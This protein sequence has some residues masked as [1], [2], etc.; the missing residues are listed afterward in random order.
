MKKIM[1]ILLVLLMLTS[2]LASCGGNDETTTTEEILKQDWSLHGFREKAKLKGNNNDG[3][4]GIFNIAD[5]N[6]F[7]SQPYF[8]PVKALMFT[9]K[10]E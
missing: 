9:F 3:I 1:S 6:L 7:S 4:F 10:W 5:F 2:V 8:K